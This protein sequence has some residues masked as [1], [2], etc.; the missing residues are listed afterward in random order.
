M[1]LAWDE[2]NK[3]D[4]NLALISKNRHSAI[5]ELPYPPDHIIVSIK[6]KPG[7]SWPRNLNLAPPNSDCIHIP[8][9]LV[10]R[11]Y[12]KTCACLSKGLKLMYY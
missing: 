5:L 3:E 12:S 10:S 8:I 9:G 2:K 11:I 4:E 1:S 6:P 7:T